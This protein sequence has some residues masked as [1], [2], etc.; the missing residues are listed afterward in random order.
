VLIPV[1]PATWEAENGR[2]AVSSQPRQMS[3]EDP[4]S[5]ITRSNGLVVYLKHLFCKCDA[6]SSEE[7]K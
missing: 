7:K 4:I 1:T 5:K 6:L 3:L 2:I